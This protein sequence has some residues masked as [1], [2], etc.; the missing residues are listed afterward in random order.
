[1]NL[2]RL[3]FLDAREENDVVKHAQAQNAVFISDD[4][5]I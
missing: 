4:Y 1:M 3:S 2:D 5:M